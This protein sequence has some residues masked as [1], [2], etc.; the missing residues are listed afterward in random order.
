MLRRSYRRDGK[1]YAECIICSEEWNIAK[2]QRVPRDGYVCPW[3][4]SKSGK[5]GKINERDID[6]VQQH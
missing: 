2:G 4:F 6:K 5:D 3:C 1:R